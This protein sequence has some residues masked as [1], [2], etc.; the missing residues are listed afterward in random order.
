M[1]VTQQNLIEA[2]L[3]EQISVLKKDFFKVYPDRESTVITNPPYDE[4]LKEENI[5]SFYGDIGNKLEKDFKRTNAWVFSG[6]LDA[7][8]YISLDIDKEFR[9]MNGGIPAKFVKYHV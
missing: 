9:L 7:M 6:N 2:G 3:D 4:R 1:K 5:N 8:K